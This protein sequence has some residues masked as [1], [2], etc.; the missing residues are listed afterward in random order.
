[1]PSHSG[2]YDVVGVGFG[3]SGIALAAAIAD[4]AEDEE[5]DPAVD[6]LFLD[7]GS[8]ASWQAEL[9]LPGTRIRHH[10]FRDF[11]TPR[12]PR[13]RFTFVN[14][15]KESDR[16]FAFGLLEKGPG[17]IEWADYCRWVA[18]QLADMVLYQHQVTE[19]RPVPDRGTPA[20]RLAV[21]ALNLRTKRKRTFHAR[22]VVLCTGRAP[23]VPDL[24]TS[25]IGRRVFHSS[26]YL[27]S[28]A[29]LPVSSEATV[30]V[31][32]SGQSAIEILLHLLENYPRTKL[33]SLSRGTGFRLHD[34]GEF[35]NEIY[36]PAAVDEFFPLPKSIREEIL[37][38]AWYTN[39]S[40]VDAQT[41]QTLYAR[42]YEE[43]VT[44]SP[45]AIFLTRSEVTDLVDD[46][47][48]LHLTITNKL[49]RA[50]HRSQVDMMI[51]CTG[52]RREQCPSVLEPLR[53]Y[54]LH[55]AENDLEVTRD[56]EV[57][58]T[59][60]LMAGLFING[61]SELSYGV[62]DA[63]SFSMVALKAERT[64]RQLNWRLQAGKGN[65]CTRQERAAM[66][67]AAL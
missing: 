63:A 10:F 31:V 62:S 24:F 51:L 4:S 55:D 40:S 11:A 45:H 14:Y 34:M 64:L 22:N 2:T 46:G 35:S 50:S 29:S 32:G 33:V 12:N 57:Q 18:D 15:L 48:Q 67:G 61:L 3:P 16:L 7:G 27:S 49:T 44:G 43:G 58:T 6:A 30:A 47:T 37:R 25:F 28:I 17:R 41:S 1:M 21:T 5:A 26:A 66:A 52:Y 38:D 56:Y 39:Y 13:S 65:V 42:R 8:M 54:L 60:E 53:G 59:H 36:F 19:I 20:D 9:L 23:H